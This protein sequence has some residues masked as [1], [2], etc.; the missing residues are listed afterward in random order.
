MKA[1]LSRISRAF[2]ASKAQLQC[3][4]C[5][6]ADISFTPL[7]SYYRDNAKAN[8]Y[9]YFGQGEMTAVDSYSCSACGASDRERLYAYWVEQMIASGRLHEGHRLIHFSPEPALG[10]LIQ[11]KGLF[12]YSTAD[13]VMPGVDYHADLMDL[14]FE[15]ESVDF[16]ICSHVLE[17]VPDDRQAIRELHRITRKSGVGI[18]MAPI[19]LGLKHTDEEASPCSPEERWRRFG[20]DDHVRL[21]AH[22]DYVQRIQESGFKLKQLGQAHFGA[23]LF[24]SLGLKDTSILYI[25]SKS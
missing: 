12:D 2:Q 13:L 7:D 15:D 23:Q 16:F 20:Q 22:N 25:V 8:G 3:P 5:K 1:L 19:I 10:A 9:Q 17:H 11:Q 14:P 24:R 6:T 21:Y 4:L 18:L